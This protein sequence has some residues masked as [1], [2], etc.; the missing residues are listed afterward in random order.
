VSG[1]FEESFRAREQ[2][3]TIR[4]ELRQ[5]ARELELDRIRREAFATVRDRLQRD[6]D[7]AEYQE[8]ERHRLYRGTHST[9]SA[10]HSHDLDHD[11]GHSL[12]YDDQ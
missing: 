4:A 11:R 12:D 10:G 1:W 5:Q 7:E 3:R 8:A 6:T 9:A 2:M